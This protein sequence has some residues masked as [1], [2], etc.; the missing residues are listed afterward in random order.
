[1]RRL[2]KNNT[3]DFVAFSYYA[4][5]VV[6]TDHRLKINNYGK[7]QNPYCDA[8]QWGWIIDP[9]GIR[10]TLNFLQERFHKPLFIV[11]NG[12]GAKDILVVDEQYGY[13]V[14]DDYRIDYMRKHLE[15]MKLAIQEGVDCRGYL[16]WGPVDI[17]SS[18]AQMKKRYGF[19]Y[20]NRENDDL[21]DMRR[22]RKKSFAWYQQVIASNGEVL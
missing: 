8:S 6:T 2:L 15:E 19:I 12:L 21:K 14:N 13:T 4:S 5:K 9:Q 10:I 17:L 20:V 7:L 1:M 3:V 16:S 11:E 22:I 18:R